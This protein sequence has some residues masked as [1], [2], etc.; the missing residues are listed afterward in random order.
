[1]FADDTEIWIE[2]SRPEDAVKLQEDLLSDWSA[3]WLLKSIRQY[4]PPAST[5]W[6]REFWDGETAI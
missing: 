3:R 1:M 6:I 2:L 4:A 5:T